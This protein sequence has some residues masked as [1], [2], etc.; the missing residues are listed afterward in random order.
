[1]PTKSKGRVGP[2]RNIKSDVKRGPYAKGGY[3]GSGS[4]D[5]SYRDSPSKPG[6]FGRPTDSRGFHRN[7]KQNSQGRITNPAFPDNYDSQGNQPG[8]R[9]DGGQAKHQPVGGGKYPVYDYGK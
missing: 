5:N 2:S 4:V 1:M 8:V 6:S 7:P 3:L 9:G